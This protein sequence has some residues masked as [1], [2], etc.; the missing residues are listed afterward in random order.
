MTRT[1]W[2][3]KGD[4]LYSLQV[5]RRTEPITRMISLK[6][7]VGPMSIDTQ[8]IL[9]GPTP[10]DTVFGQPIWYWKSLRPVLP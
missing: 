3:L 4:P 10:E 5:A 2:L 9:T 6:G 1:E 8:S 7:A